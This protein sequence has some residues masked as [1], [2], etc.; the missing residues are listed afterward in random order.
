MTLGKSPTSEDAFRSG[1]SFCRDHV[2]A[3]LDLRAAVP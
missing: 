2:S 1:T 3:N